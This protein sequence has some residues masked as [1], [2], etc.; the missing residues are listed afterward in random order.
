[1]TFLHQ[2]LKRRPT[3]LAYNFKTLLAGNEIN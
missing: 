1:M 3:G 2:D